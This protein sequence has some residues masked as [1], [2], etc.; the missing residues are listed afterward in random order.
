MA[1]TSKSRDYLGRD[2]VTPDSNAKDFLGRAC[3]A[4]DKDYLGRALIA[5]EPITFAAVTPATGAAAGGTAVTITG[6]NFTRATGVTFGGVA[7]TGFTVVS[8]TEI[9][10]TTGAHAAGAVDVVVLDPDGNGTD[11]GAFTYTA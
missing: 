6:K 2:I 11:A 1:T 4:G 9:T 10:C 5:D 7:A 3:I 8:D